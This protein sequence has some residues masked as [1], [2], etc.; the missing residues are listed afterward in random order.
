MEHTQPPPRLLKA[1]RRNT[2]LF[3]LIL[4][5]LLLFSRPLIHPNG[6]FHEI[7]DSVGGLLIAICMLGRSY[8]TLFVGGKKN[9]SVITYG[10]YS[11]VRNPLYVFSF[12][13]VIGIG[14]QSGRVTILTLLLLVFVYYYRKVVA[15]EEAFLRHKFGADFDNYCAQVPR[16]IPN[17]KNWHTPDE[18]LAQPVMVLRTM[19]DAL[20]FCIPLFLFELVQMLQYQGVLH[21]FVTLP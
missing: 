8:S 5:P 10:V 11:I 6:T 21:A 20:M 14:L 17:F 4:L 19:T 12:L 16:W 18:V 3:V 9:V 13:G 7:I 2:I 15:G 1:R